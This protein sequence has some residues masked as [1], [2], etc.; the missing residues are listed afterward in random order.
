[1]TK[2]ADIATAYGQTTDHSKPSKAIRERRC[3]SSKQGTKSGNPKTGMSWAGLAAPRAMAE[4][5]VSTVAS[6]GPASN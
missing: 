6:N 4:T 5:K 2:R 1:M 3:T